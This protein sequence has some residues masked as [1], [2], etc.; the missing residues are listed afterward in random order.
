MDRELVELAQR[1]D[2]DAYDTL[3]RAVAPRFYRIAQRILRDL[4]LAQD[5]TQQAL[6]ALWRELPRLRDADSFDSWSYQLVVRF[7]LMELRS[8]RRRLA[9]VRDLQT[10][11]GGRDEPARPDE[12]RRVADRDELE[13]AF[14]QLSEEQRA[15]VVLRHYVGL[16][17]AESADAL[18]VPT[19][20]AASRLHY[21]MRALRAALE[22]NDRRGARDGRTA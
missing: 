6:V 5:A 18:G 7:C 3:A 13:R 14:R 11:E 21:A 16:S 22:A 20:T 1:G 15:V 12:S 4:D 10:G 19:G 2:R 17:V 8:R 9:V